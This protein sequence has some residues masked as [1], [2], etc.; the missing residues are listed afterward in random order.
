MRSAVD[1]S[2]NSPGCKR[3]AAPGSVIS[4]SSVRSLRSSFTSITPRVWLRNTRNRWSSVRS[5]DDGC[6]FAGS[7]GS[8]TMRPES[9][10]SRM[11][12]S[13]RIIGGEPYL[14]G[15]SHGDP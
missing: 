2:T 13:D 14:V 7:N 8:M 6:T 11:V 4:I 3:N 9:I 5:T 10:A 15:T 1:P 12:R